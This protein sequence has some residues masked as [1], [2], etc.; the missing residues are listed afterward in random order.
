MA[1]CSRCSNFELVPTGEAFRSSSRGSSL[2]DYSSTWA[3]LLIMRCRSD[4]GFQD[5]RRF[6][7]RSPLLRSVV[8]GGFS[9]LAALP[10]LQAMFLAYDGIARPCFDLLF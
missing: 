5:W 7:A 3:S 4:G 1:C 10:P 9:H 2:D 8:L 6:S